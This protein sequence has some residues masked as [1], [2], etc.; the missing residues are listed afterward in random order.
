[1]SFKEKCEKLML[2]Q[3]EHEASEGADPEDMRKFFKIAW[4][5]DVDVDLQQVPVD[6]RLLRGKFQ[7]VLNDL[8]SQYQKSVTTDIISPALN[9]FLYIDDAAIR[10][11]L[12]PSS[13]QIPFV[14]AVSPGYEGHY[15]DD[16][17]NPEAHYKIA[18]KLL[19]PFWELVGT[20]MMGMDEVMP[21]EVGG[22]CSTVGENGL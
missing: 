18:I 22:V 9:A 17:L 5:E 15:D 14:H 7:D 4:V 12:S 8:K 6:L 21:N 20:G 19:G 10:S 16:P 1:M 3:W 11:L 2:M 13:S